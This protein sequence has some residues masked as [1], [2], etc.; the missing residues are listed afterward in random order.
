MKILQVSPRYYPDIGGV[1]EHVR[2]I[3]ERLAQK[4][5]VSV[6][7]TDPS[8]KL[9][10]EEM[11]NGVRVKRFRSWAPGEAYYFSAA[12]KKHLA[13]HSDS[14]DIVHAHNYGALPA[15]YAAQTK[16]KNKFV[17]TPHYIG[18]G[19]TFFRNLLHIPYK[20]ISAKILNIQLTSV[21]W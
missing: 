21:N 19:G 18:G 8:G 7:T 6:F 4:F 1:E 12:L 14:F 13:K 20:L 17:F 3:S 9:L 16:G 10:K 15:L 5:E 2:S 11:I